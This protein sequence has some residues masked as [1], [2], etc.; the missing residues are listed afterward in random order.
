M[1]IYIIILLI[2]LNGVFSM[3]EV[4]LIS[5]RK[6]NLRVQAAQGSKSAKRA[7]ALAEDSDKFLSTVQIGITLIGILTGIYSGATL[8]DDFASLL[9]G[10]GVSDS[11]AQI[12]APTIIVVVVTYLSIVFGELVP[13]R[14]G[15]SAAENVAKIVAAPMHY[16]SVLASPFV[17]LLS[18]SIDIVAK[19]LRLHEVESTVSEAE[20]KSIIQ[21]G[22]ECGEVQEVEQRIVDR[23]F[24]LGD[25]TIGSIMTPRHD[26]V[27]IDIS[28]SAA[29]IR[30]VVSAAP[31]SI[32]PVI[33]SNPDKLLGVVFL[34]ELFAIVNQAYFKIESIIRAPKFFHKYTEVYNALEQMR[35]EHLSYGIVCDE[36]GL[37]QGVITL[38]DVLEA[39]VGDMLGESEQPNIVVRADGSCLIDGQCPFYD[40]LLHF[41]L[42]DC[43][44]HSDY[45]TVSGLTLDI[46]GHV[47]EVGERFSWHEFD[48][49]VVDMDKARIDKLLVTY[50]A[51]QLA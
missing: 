39:L 24:S 37:T 14:I 10:W 31:H 42:E 12:I 38:R 30:D 15:M 29:E 47:P 4:A 36:F 3:A 40:F 8:S 2:L 28:M 44:S 26:L 9:A 32:Y 43:F 48:F 45:N 6:S 46:L 21:E 1:E 34:K 19:V 50:N 35:A 20:I 18:K 25:R 51:K 33:D 11:T 27:W 49:E 23:V 13:K 5:A 16:L 41:D 17:W 7:L 22:T